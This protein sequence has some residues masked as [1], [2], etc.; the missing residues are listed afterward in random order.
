[1]NTEKGKQRKSKAEQE[2]NEQEW[3]GSCGQ[4]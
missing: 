2:G 1:M 4:F 3:Q